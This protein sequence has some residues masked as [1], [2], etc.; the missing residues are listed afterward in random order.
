MSAGF[1][2]T[3][4][5]WD[6]IHHFASFPM[7][8]GVS[9]MSLDTLDSNMDHDICSEPAADGAVWAESEP[10]DVVQGV[11]VLGRYAN[12]W[13]LCV[14][15]TRMILTWERLTRGTPGP[16]GTPGE[17][18]GRAAPQPARHAVHQEGQELV[19]PVFRGPCA[20]AHPTLSLLFTTSTYR[21][22]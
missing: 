5:L 15:L 11:S 16:T 1:R 18:A 22:S 7:T 13:L 10:G 19:C 21:N 14:F 8:G 2:I 20:P 6:K 12:A 4:G 17:R 9:C 3:P